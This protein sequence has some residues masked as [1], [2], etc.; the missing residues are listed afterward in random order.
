MTGCFEN[1]SRRRR[2]KASVKLWVKE[3]KL[4]RPFRGHRLSKECNNKRNLKETFSDVA[5]GIQ[6]AWDKT[7]WNVTV[8]LITR[9]FR[10]RMIPISN[11]REKC[12]T[13]LLKFFL[14]CLRHFM[15]SISSRFNHFSLHTL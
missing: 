3:T 2:D 8:K 12:S 10:T 1:C 13:I 9:L 6:L 7:S 4:K 15:E 11:P 5:N 14:V